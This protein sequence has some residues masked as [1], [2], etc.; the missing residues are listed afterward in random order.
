MIEDRHIELIHAELDGELT[1]EQRAELG[2]LLRANPEAWALREELTRMF[3]ALAEVKNVEPPP[4]LRKSVLQALARKPAQRQGR[5]ALNSIPI[6]LRYA[7]V[8]AAGVLATAIV[9]QFGTDEASLPD[10]SELVGTIGGQER[11]AKAPI[12]RV[13][14]DLAQVSGSA[15]AYETQ[16]GIVVEL[17]LRARKPLLIV[18]TQDDRSVSLNVAAQR[19]AARERMFWVA[20]SGGA[21]V[22]LRVFSTETLLYEGVLQT[23]RSEASPQEQSE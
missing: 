10:V 21:P 8:F 4:D 20:P 1:A 7:A 22:K 19:D 5:R 3:G 23:S 11:A 12:D 6:P 9:L 16:S 17:D 2:R 13:E 15:T 14:L 18:A